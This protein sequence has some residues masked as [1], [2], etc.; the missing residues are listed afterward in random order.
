M[1]PLAFRMLIMRGQADDAYLDTVT[2]AVEAALR[3]AVPPKRAAEVLVRSG[4]P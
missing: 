4:L 1:A 2:N 3:A